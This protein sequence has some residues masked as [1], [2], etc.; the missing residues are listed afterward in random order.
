MDNTFNIF[1]KL[2]TFAGIITIVSTLSF[3]VVLLFVLL[4]LLNSWYESRVRKNYVKWDMEKVPVER[5][6][7][8]LINLVSDFAFGGVRGIL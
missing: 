5:K 1:G 4:I 6:T 2:L 8:Y 3:W 7:S